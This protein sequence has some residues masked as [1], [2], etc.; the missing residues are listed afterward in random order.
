M[1]T[2]VFVPTAMGGPRCTV[3]TVRSSQHHGCVLV[4]ELVGSVRTV[5]PSSSRSC[6]VRLFLNARNANLFSVLS[7]QCPYSPLASLRTSQPSHHKPD[8]R[9]HLALSTV[10]LSLCLITKPRGQYKDVSGDSGTTLPL[11]ARFPLDVELRRVFGIRRPPTG[12]CVRVD[13]IF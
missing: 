6:A 10:S 8:S 3:D 13:A 1:A 9:L 7:C 4:S 11:C 2:A 12:T 5:R